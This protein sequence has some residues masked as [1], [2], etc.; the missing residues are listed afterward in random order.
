PFALASAVVAGVSV[1]VLEHRGVVRGDTAIG[2]VFAGGLGIGII[3]AAAAGFEEEILEAFFGSVTTVT[4]SDLLLLG[5]L[6][7]ALLVAL[8]G[9]YKEFVYLTFDEE[10][11]E[12]SGLPVHGLNLLF[13]VLTAVAVVATLRIVGVLLVAALLILPAAASQH[14]AGTFRQSVVLAVAFA[15]AATLTGVLLAFLLGWPPGGAVVVVS[16]ALFAAAVTAA[17]LRHAVPAPA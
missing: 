4:T 11:A 1:H 15:V 10:T 16:L 14:V 2:I 7:A 9:L 6:L 17:R 3:L 8:V 13:V 5:G 12:A